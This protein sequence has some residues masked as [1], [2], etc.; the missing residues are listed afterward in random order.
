MTV[1]VQQV[2]GVARSVTQLLSNNRYGLDFYQREYGWGEAQVGEFLDDLTGRFL[3]EFDP[4]HERPHVASY[5]PYFLGPIVTELREGVRYLVDGQQ[6]ITTLSLLL[7]YVRRLLE[8][9]YPQDGNSLETLIFTTV[10][11]RKTFN[12]D[13]DEREQCLT[14][15]VEGREF[16]T[17]SEG[18]S[19]RN[20][21]N[22]YETI[23]E[24][25]SND[26]L[27]KTLPFF[28]D[29]LL[30]RV[31]LVD[32]AAPDQEMALEIFETMN[33]RG[34]RL[35]NTDMLKGYLLARVGETSVIDSLNER[36]KNRITK[37]TDVEENADAE[38][39]KNWLRSKYAET[40]RERKAKAAPGDFDVIHTAFHKWIRDN[41]NLI[42]IESASDFRRFVEQEFFPLS[43]RYLRLLE[44]T[45]ECKSGLEAVYFNAK[46]GFTLQFL[47]ILAA[48]TSDD[49]ET[50]FIEKAG[51]VASALDIFVVRR[52]VNY[53]NFGY[54]TVV[55]TIF[56]LVKKIRNRSTDE[57]RAILS[58]WL[59]SEKTEIH[60]I[61]SL[62]L[63]M[64]N[65]RHIV[66]LLARITAWLDTEMGIDDQSFVG[67]MD[68]SRKH[69]YQ[70][71]HIWADHYDRHKDEFENSYEFEIHRNK[72]GA[73]LLLPGDFNASFGDMCYDKKVELYQAQ[74]LL[75]RSLHPNAYKNNPS[76]L[77]L[78]DTY[79][80]PF[81]AYPSRFTKSDIEE[82][83]NLYKELAEIVWDPD[84]VGLS[85]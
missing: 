33:D 53:H 31:I 70:I 34:L 42:G 66:Y 28:A 55:Y 45:H 10:Y 83:Q 2:T 7:I 71:E 54:S 26:L 20:L 41:T 12:L 24:R 21:W 29:W 63:T 47:V 39:I 59:K 43:A 64:R 82:R 44:A 57:V 84:R 72:F 25:F 32:I 38:F 17:Q 56:N 40:Q 4:N 49:E 65:R 11:G 1:D 19:V 77:H 48:I 37:L 58:E 85:T 36:W 5:R 79:N 27:G 30:H 75:A 81:V 68:K 52:M 13:V 18:D 35:T 46:T 73:L 22:R 61:S 8:E 69:P 6:R 9:E 80:L 23:T 76:F 67:Y 16:D 51:L 60:G 15:I 3:D 78:C 74:N 62:S 50:T 14:A